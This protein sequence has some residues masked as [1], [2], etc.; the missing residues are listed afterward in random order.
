MDLD[1]QTIRKKIY[2]GEPYVTIEVPSPVD[3][4]SMIANGF[5]PYFDFITLLDEEKPDEYEKVHAYG[6]HVMSWAHAQLRLFEVIALADMD[7]SEIEFWFKG[8]GNQLLNLGAYTSWFYPSL[9]WMIKQGE[10]KCFSLPLLLYARD[11]IYTDTLRPVTQM[12]S[13]RTPASAVAQRGEINNGQYKEWKVIPVSRYGSGMSKGLY[14]STSDNHSAP[15]CGTFY[16]Y[17]PQSKVYL[18]YNTVYRAENKYVAYMNLCKE[19]NK[20]PDRYFKRIH[21]VFVGPAS[22]LLDYL[23]LYKDFIAKK[24]KIP[25]D[26]MMSPAELDELKLH[27][28]ILTGD[29]YNRTLAKTLHKKRYIGQFIGFYGIEDVFDQPLCILGKELGY[30]II[31]LENMVGSHQV[32]TEVLDTRNRATSFDNLVFTV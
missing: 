24:G 13:F 10:E 9:A 11:K 6:A 23:R 8:R 32:V 19:G 30:D 4:R 2:D 26:L 22:Y 3:W 21:N 31:I 17:E 14:L 7:E 25:Q 28:D 18:A 1:L 29:G 16:Y 5:L 12:S 20:D 27:P 15:F